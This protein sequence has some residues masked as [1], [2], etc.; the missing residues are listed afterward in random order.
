MKNF[1]EKTANFSKTSEEM[2]IFLENLEWRLVLIGGFIALL[3]TAF[4]SFLQLSTIRL[5]RS[6]AVFIRL[7]T[8]ILILPWALVVDYSATLV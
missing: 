2:Q 5:A 3:T 7:L 6:N 4:V 1:I 8:P